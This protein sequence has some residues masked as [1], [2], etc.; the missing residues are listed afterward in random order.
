[1]SQTEIN[2]SEMINS[3]MN[4]A[5]QINK[6]LGGVQDKLSPEQKAEFDKLLGAD[7]E[8]AKQMKKTQDGLSDAMKKM[9]DFKNFS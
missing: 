5:K 1:M 3:L 6:F 7:G 9:N 8:F 4:T 2:P